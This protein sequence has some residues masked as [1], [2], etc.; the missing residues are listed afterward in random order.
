VSIEERWEALESYERAVRDDG[1]LRLASDELALVAVPGRELVRV[2]HPPRIALSDWRYGDALPPSRRSWLTRVLS[3]AFDR[4]PAPPV[5][6]SNPYG[7]MGAN[8]PAPE[9]LRSAFV[10]FASDL[11]FAFT[12]VPFARAC[13]D[14]SSP[15]AMEPWDFSEVTFLDLPG[16]GLRS[17]CGVCRRTVDL[18]L[19]EGRAGLRMGLGVV[20]RGPPLRRNAVSGATVLDQQG[21][22]LQFLRALARDRRPLGELDLPQRTAL[23]IG[24]DEMAEMEA[25]E[26]EWRAAEEIAAIMDGELTQVPGFEEFRARVLGTD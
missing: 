13:P 24:L 26:R 15:L 22:G 8:M 6:G 19:A 18:P 11:T 20:T 21:G 9:W 1:R 25:L 23:V 3:R 7:V 4:V 2:G 12:Q 5:G 16:G 10:E 17:R 14:C